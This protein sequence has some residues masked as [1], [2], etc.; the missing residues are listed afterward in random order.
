[1]EFLVHNVPKL[2]ILVYLDHNNHKT[3][4]PKLH[5]MLQ[6]HILSQENNQA[7]QKQLYY[8]LENL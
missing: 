3:D 6:Q 4:L 1:M 7:L 2:D 8:Q 5:L